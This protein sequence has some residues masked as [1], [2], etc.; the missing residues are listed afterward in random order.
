M[1]AGW[2][3]WAACALLVAAAQDASA[4]RTSLTV[5]RLAL[6]DERVVYRFSVSAHDLAIALGIE[7]DLVSP[8]PRQ[9]FEAHAGTLERYLHRRLR[10]RAGDDTSC[11]PGAP[12]V[13]YTRLP[14]NL[15]IE[16]EFVCPRAP[17]RL[18]LDYGL[19]FDV[20]PSHRG[21][22]RIALPQGEEEFLLD[23][24]L[25]H[26]EWPVRQAGAGGGF[27]HFA[28]VFRLGVEHILV[29]YD[30]L[31]FLLALLVVAARFWATVQVVTAFTLAHS[32]T[33]ALAWFGVVD[34][35]ARLVE[36]L[37][38]L[39]IA[40]VAAENLL[41]ARLHRR[42]LL[43]G[44]LGLVHG[45][46]FYGVLRELELARG[47]AV[48]TL[49]AF[50]LGVEAGQVAVVALAFGPLFWWTRQRW[51]RPA[52][53]ACSGLILALATFWALQRGLGLGA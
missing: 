52:A 2:A 7:T 11:A 35:P 29:G 49:L 31:L 30:H 28:R 8:V 46:G 12:S 16:L 42:W 3:A 47:D 43:A 19:F 36:T 6:A 53:Q 24:S 20:D 41:G 34:P 21:I 5:S 9:A 1:R 32:L 25:T 40:Y 15:L 51:Y 17:E 18:I 48:M 27:P 22:G 10:L 45:L 50:N 39:S 26:L 23:R 38:A 37:I 4:H 13:D 33:L 14:E 44:V